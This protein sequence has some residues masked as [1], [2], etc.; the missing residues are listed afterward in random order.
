MLPVVAHPVQ[1]KGPQGLVPFFTSS[2]IGE[3]D[4]DEHLINLFSK[5]CKPEG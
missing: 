3:P 2:I 1:I 5:N 4:D